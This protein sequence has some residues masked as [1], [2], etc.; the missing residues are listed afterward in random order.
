MSIRTL[1]YCTRLP[2]KCAMHPPVCGTHDRVVSR[3]RFFT[4]GVFGCNIAHRRS[5]TVL[6]MLYKIR[7]D[8]MHPL[9]GALPVPYVIVA[10]TWRS[11]AAHRYTYVSPRYRTSQYR[12]TFIPPSVSLWNDLALYSMVWDW[13]VTRAV[14]MFFIGLSS[15]I[16]ICILLFIP[17][18]SFCQL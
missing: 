2:L 17:F 16:H 1:N 18:S 10:V 12:R 4:G 3:A 9:Y 6:C 14:P 13:R 5:I 7:R 11:L 15:S 8:M